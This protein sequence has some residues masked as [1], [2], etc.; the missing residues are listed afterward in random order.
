MKFKFKFQII[1]LIIINTILF[2][3]FAITPLKAYAADRILDYGDNLV[4]VIDP[5]HGGEN[6]GTTENGFLEKEMNL[7]TAKA[8]YEELLK[9]DNVEV[10]L[11]R[12]TD[13][14]LS[15]KQRAEIA[16]LVN[17]DF[18]FS[19]HYNASVDHDLFGSEVWISSYA[20]F[21][22]YGYQFGHIQMQTMADYGLF[23]RGVKTKLN[24]KQNADYYGIIRHAVSFDIPAVIIEHC[25]VDESRDN[26]YCDTEDELQKFGILDATSVAK[27]FG[28]KSTA[29]NVDY[30][31]DNSFIPYAEMDTV[32]ESTLWDTSAPEEAYISLVDT[33][34]YT[35][36]VTINLSGFDPDS[37]LMY[38]DYSID[39]GKTYSKLYPWSQSN[40][41]T[42]EYD[43][44]FEVSI[45]IPSKT[46]PD[47][48]FRVYNQY[49]AFSET[50]Q[51]HFDETFLY[52]DD[53]PVEE[54]PAIETDSISVDF[55]NTNADDTDNTLN[56]LS[57]LKLVLLIVV[58]LFII[59][60]VS[61]FISYQISSKKRRKSRRHK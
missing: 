60:F 18:L 21:N 36:I 54:I 13:E 5:G 31:T 49:D 7:I 53:K 35:G 11:T 14:E 6:E 28:L 42:F 50:N 22:S 27:Y 30:N 15:L 32:V 47:I 9:Y 41:M 29:L 34:F 10:Y 38:Y 4:I 20:P 16:A 2:C 33:N 39:G 25:H 37:P 40:V 51:I 24:E 45:S 26:V 48:I 61:Q 57:F 56:I 46:R 44:T 58:L 52:G 3:F 19:I 43:R 17:A 12:E 59:L 55:T 23:I 1:K 8:M